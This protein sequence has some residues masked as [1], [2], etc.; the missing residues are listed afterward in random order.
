M[1]AMGERGEVHNIHLVKDD[2]FFFGLLCF[3]IEHVADDMV[4]EDVGVFTEK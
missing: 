2:P 4:R 3:F 1:P